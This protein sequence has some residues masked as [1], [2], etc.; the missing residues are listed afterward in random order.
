[1]KHDKVYLSNIIDAIDRILDYTEG[2]DKPE[3]DQNTM[4]QDA[5]IRNFEIIGE[6]TKNISSD[7]RKDHNHIP[8][9]NMAGMRD[10]LIHNY[11]G[12]DLDA[13]W[14]TITD[15]LPSLHENISDLSAES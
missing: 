14:Q 15:I 6:A 5:V 7:F 11:M 4:I 9:K 10:K 8:W 12:V 13:V 3:F 1:M 2:V